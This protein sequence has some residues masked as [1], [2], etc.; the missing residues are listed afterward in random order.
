MFFSI[1]NKLSKQNPHLKSFILNRE[2]QQLPKGVR[3]FVYYNVEGVVRYEPNIFIGSFSPNS[4]VIHASEIT[5]PPL[6]YVL[7]MNGTMPDERLHEITYFSN[8]RLNEKAQIS[9]NLN[10]LPTFLKSILD[11][12][13]KEEIENGLK[14]SFE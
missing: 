10:I 14:M 12:R 9:Q 1:D 8:Y 3:V 11:Y 7:V 4:E 6:G 13:T 5:F 2:S